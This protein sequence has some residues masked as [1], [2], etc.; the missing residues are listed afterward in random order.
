MVTRSQV[1]AFGSAARNCASDCHPNECGPVHSVS[2]D[3][4]QANTLLDRIRRRVRR[5]DDPE[6]EVVWNGIG[7]LP[8]AGGAAG[9]GST[10]SGMH[11]SIG[12]LR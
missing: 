3:G 4:S 7:P 11:F 9:L 10:L 12:K 1:P 2:H 6:F 5:R 8:G